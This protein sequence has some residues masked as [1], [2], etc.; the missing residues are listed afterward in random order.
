MYAEYWKPMYW[1]SRIE[2]ISG[3]VVVEKI[4]LMRP[5]VAGP[6]TPALTP[7]AAICAEVTPC[8]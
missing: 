8:V 2:R 3:N 7:L 5:P 6:T 4:W 1:K